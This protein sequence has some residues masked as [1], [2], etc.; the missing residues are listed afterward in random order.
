MKRSNENS[1]IVGILSFYDSP[2]GTT[3]FVQGAKTF[4][5]DKMQDLCNNFT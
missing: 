4:V 3:I 5:P 1:V 2:N